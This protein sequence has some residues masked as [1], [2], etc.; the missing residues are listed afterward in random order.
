MRLTARIILPIILLSLFFLIGKA[1][2]L[3]EFQALETEMARN[4]ERISRVTELT[5][6][7]NALEGRRKTLLLGY[8]HQADG[9]TLQ[10]FHALSR[11]FQETVGQLQPWLDTRQGRRIFNRYKDIFAR[12]ES[13]SREV[14]NAAR[15]QDAGRQDRALANWTMMAEMMDALHQDILGYVNRLVDRSLAELGGARARFMY[16]MIVLVVISLAFIAGTV[17]FHRRRVINP[18]LELTRTANDISVNLKENDIP[19]E[20]PDEIGQL[21]ASFNRMTKRL[22]QANRELENFNFIAGHDLQEPSRII[23]NYI[24]FLEEDL[25][26]AIPH[27]VK[28]DLRFIRESASRMRQ[29]IQDLQTYSRAKGVR[30][31]WRTVA[32]DDCLDE[33]VRRLRQAIEE[34]GA[35]VSREA[36][37]HIP[38]DAAMLTSVLQNLLDNAIRFRHPDVAPEITVNA[39]ETADRWEV[40]VTDN[41]IGIE[42]RHRELIF[43]PFKRL[44]RRRD[45]EGSGI[46]LA[47]VSEVM[48]R[49]GGSVQ[50]ESDTPH[51][52]VFILTFPTTGGEESRMKIE[53]ASVNIE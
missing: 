25:G 14:I 34:N 27:E 33:V 29:L 52:S 15:S 2:S 17:A 32:L 28:E 1:W 49:H 48:K 22:L 13:V 36:L 6:A 7:L 23:L 11:R 20:G 39:M 50:V 41:G 12:Q 5:F 46:G 18:L 40:R 10:D 47:I 43:T 38:G 8:R 44:N 16:R 30:M 37:P 24:G 19:L 3:F 45:Y 42:P 26:Q 51:G 31:A 35:R 4:N 21:A 9:E 53:T